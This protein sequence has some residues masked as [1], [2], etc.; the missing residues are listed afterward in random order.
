MNIFVKYKKL[1]IGIVSILMVLYAVFLLVIPNIIN[2]NNFKKDIQKI[3]FDSAKLNFDFENLKIVTTPNLKAGVKI[4]GAKLSYPNE[5]KIAELKSAEVKLALLPLLLKTIQVSDVVVVNPEMNLVYTKD[6][7]FDVVK[8]IFDNVPVS[9][10]TNETAA[11]LPLKISNKLPKVVVKDYKLNLKDE[12]TSNKII[13]DGQNFV[14]DNT[15]I[16]KKLEIMAKGKFLV[17]NSENILYDVKVKS[18]WPVIQSSTPTTNAPQAVPQIDFINELVKF[19][20]KA[21][22]VTDLQI[23][24]HS[25]HVDIVGDLLVDKISIVLDGKKLPDSYVKLTSAGHKIHFDSNLYIGDNEKAEILANITQGKKKNI[26]LNVKID[27][28][29]FVGIQN[30]VTALL[31]SFNIKNDLKDFV[32]RGYI[33][34]NFS[35]FKTISP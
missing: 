28:L 23:K 34:A 20:P 11:E 32:S 35:L 31:N 12:K 4:T 27:K 16:N 21:E 17:N 6:F 19:N 13:L 26:D 9:Q 29:T 1:F 14:L 22:I 24:E 3:V 8:Y 10:S 5:N 33:T 15:E 30:F 18:F 25:G 2:L 7:E